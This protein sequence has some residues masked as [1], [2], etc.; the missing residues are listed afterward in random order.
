MDHPRLVA[1]IL[2]LSAAGFVAIVM[3]EGYTDRAVVPTKNDRPT[4]GFGSTF[5]EDG[6]PVKLGD[7][8]TP[9]KA[10]ARS[11]AHIAKDEALLKPCVTGSLTQGEYDVLID[12]AYQYGVTA[13]CRSSM[14]RHIN[15]GAYAES[16]EAYKLYRFSG[17][18]D[19]SVPGNR[20]CA[21]V[22][23]RNL[24]RS[25][26]CAAFGLEIPPQTR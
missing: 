15:A 10:V 5:R 17:G 19:C 7:K 14:V 2:S 12:F 24:E 21:G 26:K 13:T 1:A 25:A 6:T 23:A 20:I 9:P 22:W 18:Y 4:V 11:A 8:I 16:C 3:Q